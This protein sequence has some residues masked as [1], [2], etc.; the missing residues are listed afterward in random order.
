MRFL[1]D[2]QLPRRLS[3]WLMAAGHEALHTL[4]LPDGNRTPDEELN[5]LSIQGGYTLVT[6]DA[7][8]VTSFILQQRPFKLL[9]I[10]TGNITNNALETMIRQNLPQIETL[11]TTY[12]FI[13]MDKTGLIIHS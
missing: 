11:L 8:F 5:R 12:S 9:F 6:K 3:F 10:S 13:E 2:A 1:I 7:D 4:D